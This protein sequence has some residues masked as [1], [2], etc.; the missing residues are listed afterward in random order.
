MQPDALDRSDFTRPV[1]EETA[2]R[3]MAAC[4]RGRH[5]EVERGPSSLPSIDRDMLHD[6]AWGYVALGIVFAALVVVA[7]GVGAGWIKP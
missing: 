4:H 5:A 3:W 6:K 7:A 1:T 2:H